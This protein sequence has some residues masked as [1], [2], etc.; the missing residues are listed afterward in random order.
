MHESCCA[1]SGER[2]P[3]VVI[4]GG[5]SAAFASTIRAV[6]LGARVTLINAGLPIGG[7]CVNVG[8]VPS[9]TLI[10]AAEA[11]WR[12]AHHGFA[13]IE[14]QSRLT[15]FAEVIAQKRALVGELRS[16]KYVDVARSLEGV[17]IIEGRAKLLGARA[18]EAGGRRI[19]ADRII[20]ATGARPAVPAIPGLA[21]C[22]Y[23]TNETAF[24]LEELP[25][26]LLVIGGRYIALETA[27]MFARFGTR[28]T[29]LQ[30]SERILPTESAALTDALTRYL[31]GEGIDIRAN[32]AIRHVARAR[33][34]VRVVA[35]VAGEEQTFEATH[36]LVATGRRPNTT[37]LG[38]DAAGVRTDDRGFVAVDDALET[39]TPGIFAAGDVIGEPMFVYTAAYEGRLAAENA[40]AD[41]RGRRD[42]TLVP[43]VIFTDPQV[44]GIGLDETTAR[45]RGVDAESSRLPLDAVPRAL[46][47]RDTRGFIELVRDRTSDRLV[48][49]RVLAPEGG[50]LVM[51]VALAMRAGLTTRELAGM[52]YPYLTLS[53][54]VKLAALAFEKDVARL[55]CCAA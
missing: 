48:G 31:R 45:A 22:G 14:G 21:E 43:W 46:V 54:G 2:A 49:A 28:V 7:T 13:G 33:R 50:E 30:R 11:H 39:S 34:D 26:S 51:Q 35:T 29:L 8:C 41:T 20:L 5:G 1:K 19:D 4:V 10:R 23:L 3:H 18:V 27:Q 12:P 32:V 52:L 16:A 38:L 15:S 9:K 40:L 47:A 24:E 17:E 6:E 42:Y 53:E 36:V 37:N 44:A 25:K 55:S